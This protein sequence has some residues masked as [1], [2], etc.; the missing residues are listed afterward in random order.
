M[1]LICGPPPCT[2]TGWIPTF[3]SATMSSAKAALSVSSVI[4]LPPYLT[5]TILP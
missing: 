1:A 4:A 3:S 5:T 2:T